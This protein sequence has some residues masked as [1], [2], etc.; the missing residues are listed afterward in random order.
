MQKTSKKQIVLKERAGDTIRT[1][2][3]DKNNWTSTSQDVTG[4]F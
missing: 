3:V 2:G 4:P 1:D